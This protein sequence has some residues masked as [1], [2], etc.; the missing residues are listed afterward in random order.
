M[1]EIKNCEAEDRNEIEAVQAE[2]A[3]AEEK[4]ERRSHSRTEKYARITAIAT[5]CILAVLVIS[6][7]L[8]LPRAMHIM[9]QIETEMVKVDRIADSVEDT[10]KQ[11]SQVIDGLNKIDFDKLSE[12]ISSLS[13]AIKTLTGFLG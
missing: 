3:P 4:H 12:S 10:L 8:V 1:S 2:P 6:A 7:L 11:T 5:C 13:D 9:T